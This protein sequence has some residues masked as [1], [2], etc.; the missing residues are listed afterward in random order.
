MD[1]TPAQTLAL[2]VGIGS[3]VTLIS[4]RVGIPAVLPLLL[5]G[6]GLGKS[7]LEVLD[8]DQLG[9]GLRGLI[10]VAVALLIFEGSLT[11]DRRTL[12]QS[13]RAVRGLLSIGVLVTWGLAALGAHYVVGLD[14]SFAVLLGALLIVTGPTVVQPILRRIPLTPNLHAAL[15]AEGILIDPIGAV[16]AVAT[17]EAVRAGFEGHVGATFGV[18][19]SYVGPLL[20]GLVIGALTGF[21]GAWLM[22]RAEERAGSHA[23]GGAL[24]LIGMGACMTG[25]GMAEMTAREAG[26]VAAAACGVVIA[27]TK[28]H[29][30]EELRRF[31]E[32][33]STF[34]VGTLFLL[35]AARFD[36]AWLKDIGASEALFVVLIVVLIR[37][38]SVGLSTVRSAMSWRERAFASFLAPRGIVAASL[39]SIVAIEFTRLARELNESVAL[40]PEQLEGVDVKATLRQA[41]HLIDS[42]RLVETL[43]FVVI[44]VT[45]ALGGTFSGVMARLLKVRA[46]KPNGVLIVG[47]QRLGRDLGVALTKLGVPVRLVDT[48]A[49]NIAAASSWGIPTHLGDA[50]DANWI[51]TDVPMQ[52]IGWVFSCTDNETVDAVVARW[53]S[54]VI[55]PDK[56]FRW[57]ADTPGEGSP[58]RPA[59]QY[60]RPLRHLLFQL[61]IDAARV[62]TWQ[63]EREGGLP[64]AT[65]DEGTV[66]LLEEGEEPAEGTVVVGVVMGPRLAAEEAAAHQDDAESDEAESDEAAGDE[67]EGDEASDDAEPEA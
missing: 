1:A 4:F 14:W 67:T 59:I 20:V 7:G 61:D 35:L 47:G 30:A 45:V 34:L 63:G 56:A 10:T 22:R 38:V 46:G 65:V 2:A 42:G 15:M 54:R 53:A 55:G 12:A 50:T 37:P 11:L 8:A 60:G 28:L 31:K 58:G 9:G 6:I 48:N 16:I 51:E 49:G 5:V 3:I 32:Q 19:W 33:I 18:V 64:F 44:L 13:P 66:T 24:A 26:L 57:S 52:H 40:P 39:A 62:E 36:I 23:R 29:G 17:L 21:A 41:Q 27:N 25:V 43:V